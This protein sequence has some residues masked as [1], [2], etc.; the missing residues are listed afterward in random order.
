MLRLR[1]YLRLIANV[2]FKCPGR[3]GALRNHPSG[4]THVR[5]Q[6]REIVDAALRLGVR[7][8]SQKDSE[9]WA[10]SGISASRHP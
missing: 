4:A 9:W 1:H 3:I 7:S 10:E 2:W 5:G 6:P 8:Y